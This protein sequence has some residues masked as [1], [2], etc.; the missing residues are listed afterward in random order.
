MSTSYKHRVFILY[1]AN[2]LNLFN[3]FVVLFFF[4][5]LKKGYKLTKQGKTRFKLGWREVL[6]SNKPQA[7]LLSTQENHAPIVS[8]E[9]LLL[10]FQ[11]E[12]GYLN[13]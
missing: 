7:K 11:R 5:S 8:A 6:T 12:V 10:L 13:F 3:F 1:F 4:Y 2:S 9:R